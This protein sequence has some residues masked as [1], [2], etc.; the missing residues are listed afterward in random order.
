MPDLQF[1]VEGV[2]PERVAVAPLL[3]FK[4]RI[5]E[6]LAAGAPPTPIHA[7]TLSCQL[8]IEPARRRY[9]PR[10]QERL[11]DLFGTPERWGQTLR[12][13]LWTHASVVVRPFA[14]TT[15]VDLSVPCSYDFSL[16]A[17]KYFDALEDGEIPLCFLFSGTVFYE[18]GERGL[19]VAQVPWDREAYYR[20]PAA[21]W[22]MLM[23]LYYPNSAWLC[24]RKDIFDRL[25]QFKS[26]QGL[27]TW[28]QALEGLLAADVVSAPLSPRGRGA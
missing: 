19:Q 13:L 5:S 17:T 2:E 1:Q 15:V 9:S 26:R 6:R 8:R 14:G 28:E 20:L 27:A 24:V 12:P 4:L 11:L 25:A 10:Q 7:A 3:R 18:A 22:K 16:A 23:E 21:T